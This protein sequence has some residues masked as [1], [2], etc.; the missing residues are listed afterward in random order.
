MPTNLPINIDKDIA[1]FTQVSNHL[2]EQITNIERG[3][4][5]LG[6]NQVFVYFKNEYSVSIIQGWAAL[7]AIEIAVKSPGGRLLD[8]FKYD[9]GYKDQIH[10][11]TDPDEIVKIMHDVSN[12]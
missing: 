8:Y 4:N 1:Y 12:L 9:E 7:Y 6:N 3:Y 2:K 10:R 5:F 11:I